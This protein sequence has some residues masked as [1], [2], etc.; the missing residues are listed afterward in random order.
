MDRMLI[1]CPTY[2]RPAM[3]EDM[4]KSYQKTKAT[5]PRQPEGWSDMILGLSADDNCIPQ[6]MELAEKYKVRAQ[7][8]NTNSTTVIFNTIWAQNQN[9]FCYH[10]TNDD[11][12]YLTEFWDC[13]FIDVLGQRGG[14]IVYGDDQF[15]GA[16][17]CT[18]PCISASVAQAVGWLQYPGLDKLFG[19]A[20][21]MR[22][23]NLVPCIYW[24]HEMKIDHKHW[25]NGKREQDVTSKEYLVHYNRENFVFKLWEQNLAI[26]DV[27]KVKKLFNEEQLTINRGDRIWQNST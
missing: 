16:G 10:M 5:D 9:Y 20:V 14:G 26:N 11:V 21:W 2:K 4:L 1:I 13:V 24:H 7:V 27:E 12:I 15:H 6:Y 22:I 17:L 19:D 25:I 8:F 23:G 18:L 3:A